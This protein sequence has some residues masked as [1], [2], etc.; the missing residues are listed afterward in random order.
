MRGSA[1]A[2]RLLTG[3]LR[4]WRPQLWFTYHL[5]QKAPDWLGP[6]IAKAMAIPYVVAEAAYA[7][8]RAAGRWDA[9][10]A[11]VAAALRQADT[12]LMLNPNDEQCVAPL[13]RR[14][15]G[16]VHEVHAYRH[17]SEFAVWKRRARNRPASVEPVLPFLSVTPYWRAAKRRP[18]HRN[19]AARRF[20]IPAAPPWLLAVGMMRSGDKLDSY[21]LLARALIGLAD[22]PWRLIVVGD[23]PAQDDVR[24]SFA[25]LRRR[26]HFLGELPARDL[27]S[28]YAVS[29]LFV[30]PAIN[31]AI[32]M[33]ILEAQAAGLPAV[34]GETGAT[35]VIVATGETGV[36]VPEGGLLPFRR[37]IGRLLAG[38]DERHALS[39]AAVRRTGHFH[40]IDRA[41]SHLDSVVKAAVARARQRRSRR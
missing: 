14:R 29:D 33:A 25:P 15:R 9:G 39:K 27:V 32:G 20:G 36:L 6:P 3:K 24:G 16:A 38:P 35:G 26:V 23:G 10:L 40:D 30:W 18:E 31:E 28:L 19:A 17:L 41:A 1:L 34:V 2:K 37:A 5:Y 13:L 11:A 4:R 21:R 12:V 22:R 8:K 7:P